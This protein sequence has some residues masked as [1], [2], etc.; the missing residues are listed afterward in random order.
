MRCEN[1]D[2]QGEK[3]IRNDIE[4]LCLDDRAKLAAWK[5]HYERLS[6]FDWDRTPS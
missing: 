6:N 2:V 5:K 1:F 3:P 4:E